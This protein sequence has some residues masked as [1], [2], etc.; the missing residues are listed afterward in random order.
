[1][2]RRSARE[3]A[4]KLTFEYLF[5]NK[6]NDT[7][8]ELLTL[9]SSL[10]DD[11]KDYINRVYEGIQRDYDKLYALISRHSGNF[12][13]DRIYKPDLAAM[14]LSAYELVNEPDISAA[15]SIS[16]AIELVKKYSSEK[17]NTFVNGILGA[18]NKEVRG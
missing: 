7:T 17:S 6:G 15:V 18:I 13:A 14:I 3:A 1:M 16:S 11:D 5:Y 4:Y 2:S 8:L 10:S 9:D 12:T